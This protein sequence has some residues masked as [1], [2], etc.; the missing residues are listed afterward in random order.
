MGEWRGRGGELLAGKHIDEV[1]RLSS[2][3]H[4]SL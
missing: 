2:S 3:S 4:F 1:A